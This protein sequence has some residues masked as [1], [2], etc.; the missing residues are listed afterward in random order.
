MTIRLPNQNIFDRFLKLL[1]KKRGIKLPGEAYEKFGQ[2]AYVKAYK[3]SFWRA[4][5]RSRGEDLPDGYIDLSLIEDFR[6]EIKAG[7]KK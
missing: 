1:R 3:E 7:D 6:K 2:Y 4:L 5:F